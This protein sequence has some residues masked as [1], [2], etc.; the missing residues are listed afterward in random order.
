MS[1][2]KTSSKSLKARILVYPRPEILDPQGKAVT[3]SLDR[4][5]FGQVEEV[6]VGKSFDIVLQAESEEQAR[7]ALARMADKILANG[8]VE[9]FEV[10]IL[11]GD[12]S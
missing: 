11:D 10:E 5:G 7:E 4:L 6:R 8:V 12:P 2:S 9:D 3:A 1:K